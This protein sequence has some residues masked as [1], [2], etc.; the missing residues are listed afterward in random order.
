VRHVNGTSFDI[1]FHRDLGDRYR[2]ECF[3]PGK[4]FTRTF[5]KFTLKPVGFAGSTY[6]VPENHDRYLTELYGDW[7]VPDP[8]FDSM[9]SA[10]NLDPGSE[11]IS[12]CYA[13]SRLSD[14][15]LKADHERASAYCKQALEL[16]PENRVIKQVLDWLQVQACT[17]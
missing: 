15:L 8:Y 14:A 10:R 5:T 13:Y 7:R 3:M 16:D 9:V 6:L 1:Y 11:I 12:T 4:S 17:D 2:V